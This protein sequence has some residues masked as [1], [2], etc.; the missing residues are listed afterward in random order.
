MTRLKLY[1]TLGCH[2]CEQLEDELRRLGRADIEL[3]R[4]E[5]ADDEALL[6]RYGMRIPVLV[7]MQGNELERGFETERLVDWLHLRELLAEPAGLHAAP[8]DDAS[9]GVRW[10]GGRRFLG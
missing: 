1:N 2:L 7:D 5:I 9:S 10:I 4:I 8:A 6:E 3:E